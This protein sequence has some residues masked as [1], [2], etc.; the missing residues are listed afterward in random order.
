MN[1]RQLA[2]PGMGVVLFL[3]VQLAACGGGTSGPDAAQPGGDDSSAGATAAAT[4]AGG[5]D[6][7]LAQERLLANAN[8]VVPDA[9]RIVSYKE[10]AVRY[11]GPP[12]MQTAIVSYEAELEFTADTYFHTDH[13]AGERAQVYGE[14]E[15]LNEGGHWRLMTMGIDPR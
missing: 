1:S 14:I 11:D 7:A 2:M 8:M 5:P 3:V 15:Y 6:P 13:K 9:A 4:L 12:E 10:T